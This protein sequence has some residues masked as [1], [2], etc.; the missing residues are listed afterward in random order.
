[1]ESFESYLK[2]GII[3]KSFKDIQRDKNLIK[4][5]KKRISDLKFLDIN[6]LPKLFFE[7]I[8]DAIKDLLLAVLLYEGYK[9]FSHKAPITYLSKKRFNIYSINKLDK[10]RYKRNSSRYYGE[11]ISIEEAKDIRS[12]YFSIKNKL[13]K[14][15]VD[16]EK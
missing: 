10:F 9:T 11:E 2:K 5:S 13:N 14:I 16:F 3:K 12:F 6:K 7:N 1:M 15:L 8:Y 4:D